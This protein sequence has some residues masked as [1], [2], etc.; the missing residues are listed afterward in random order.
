[1]AFTV[2]CFKPFVYVV[3]HKLFS[4]V[5]VL[6]VGDTGENHALNV[7]LF[8]YSDAVAG[9]FRIGCW[10]IAAPV[11]HVAVVGKAEENHAVSALLVGIFVCVNTNHSSA[12]AARCIAVPENLHEIA[13]NGLL[14]DGVVAPFVV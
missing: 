11:L 4:V 14:P 7:G 2:K 9:I 10:A 5:E 3:E 12:V 1:M 13:R 6:W 8:A